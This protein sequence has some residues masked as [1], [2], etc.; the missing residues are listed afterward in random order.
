VK[1]IDTGPLGLA[2]GAQRHVWRIIAICALMMGA[3][4]HARAAA[5]LV[6]LYETWTAE[7]RGIENPSA[8]TFVPGDGGDDGNGDRGTFFIADV[9][10]DRK[11]KIV[12]S[13]LVALGADLEP[14]GRGIDLHGV[15]REPT[16]L[17]FHSTRK[18]FF[19]TDNDEVELHEID[20]QGRR[21]QT[22]DLSDLG[23]SDPEGVAFNS[24]NGTLF[25]AD[26]RAQRILEIS[27]DGD[28][29]RTFSVEDIAGFR[30]A[31]GI[32]FDP[33]NGHLYVTT[34]KSGALF[35]LTR[36][37]TVVAA[38]D[39]HVL[40]SARP[41]GV[42][43]APTSDPNDAPE[44]LHLFV[45]D[46]VSRKQPQGRLLEIALMRRPLTAKHVTSLNGDV[47]GFGFDGTE[48]NFAAGDLNHNGI[49]ERG[50]RLPESVLGDAD[51]RKRHSS[52]TDAMVLAREE[53]P[54]TIDHTFDLRTQSADPANSLERAPVTPL[55]A[56]L[57]L[58]I[59]DA[60][61]RAGTRNVV[62]VDGRRVGEVVG[63]VQKELKAGAIASTVID[64]APA[65]LRELS[66]GSARIEISR[67]PGTGSDDIMIDYSR[68]EIAVA[69]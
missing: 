5:S 18:T 12:A 64:L 8:I 27:A 42:A 55:W 61:T 37:G 22:I 31:E 39:M 6:N 13:R 62:W 20:L 33:R 4:P 25:V 32:A 10:Y 26:G 23:A 53:L 34:G 41:R 52:S 57:T 63:S 46:D 15:T 7:G 68:L 30:E 44:D 35:E 3:A 17:A 54:I 9:I 47:D 38:F 2:T 29:I 28:L 69:R 65:V 45:V 58:I 51:P 66:D 48:T 16:G 59:G 14:L 67:D 40:G 36:G 60:R 49:L 24:T 56:R 11:E 50:E 1:R 21:I 19:I 43:L